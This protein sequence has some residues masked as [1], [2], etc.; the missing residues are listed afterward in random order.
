MV[1]RYILEIEI[2]VIVVLILLLCLR[3]QKK[4]ERR[5]TFR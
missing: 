2:A 5:C 3:F 4:A 1:K